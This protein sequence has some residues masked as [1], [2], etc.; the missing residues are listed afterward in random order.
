MGGWE[1]KPREWTERK[2]G[3]Y[4]VMMWEEEEGEERL[5]ND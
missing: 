1:D 3:D 2:W 5:N 4:S